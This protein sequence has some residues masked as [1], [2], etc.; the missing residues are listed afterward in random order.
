MAVIP[1]VATL[2]KKSPFSHGWE[3]SK[4]KASGQEGKPWGRSTGKRTHHI[5]V[6]AWCRQAQKSNSLWTA[7]RQPQVK[8]II[9]KGWWGLGLADIWIRNIQEMTGKGVCCNIGAGDPFYR[10]ET[11]GERKEKFPVSSGVAQTRLLVCWRDHQAML[12][13]VSIFN[14]YKGTEA[15]WK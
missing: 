3:T 12:S 2:T 10:R 15:T 13:Q 11:G 6:S 4:P 7:C 1:G 8:Q 14:A 5:K 9:K